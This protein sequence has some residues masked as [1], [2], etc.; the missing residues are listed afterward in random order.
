VE[1]GLY[2][3]DYAHETPMHHG[4]SSQ[5]TIEDIDE[6]LNIIEDVFREMR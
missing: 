5:H 1:R 4:Y 6:A 3:H 2:L